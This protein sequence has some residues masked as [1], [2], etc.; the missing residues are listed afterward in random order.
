MNRITTLLFCSS[1]NGFLQS[2]L[3]CQTTG[4]TAVQDW[5]FYITG[6]LALLAPQKS[7]LPKT[8][9]LHKNT[10]KFCR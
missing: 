9:F 2:A 3:T 10:L 8:S 4:I 5:L 7:Y 1:I 6:G